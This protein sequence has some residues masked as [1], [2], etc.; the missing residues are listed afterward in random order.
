MTASASYIW[1]SATYYSIF[2]EDYN[3]AGAFGQMDARLLWND[4]DDRYTMILFVRNLLDDDGHLG[5]Q[6][7]GD[8]YVP[9]AQQYTIIQP[10][11][12]GIEIQRRFR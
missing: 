4:D 2:N 6:R 10:R 5:A 12:F 7:P 1:R 9:T 8:P 11:T 3:R